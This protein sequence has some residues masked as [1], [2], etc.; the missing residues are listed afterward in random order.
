MF[1]LNQLR[2]RYN[3]RSLSSELA[4]I[5]MINLDDSLVDLR[6]RF[7]QVSLLYKNRPTC[8]REMGKF[9]YYDNKPFSS[10]TIHN[11]LVIFVLLISVRISE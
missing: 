11:S 6:T 8:V 5:V 10:S 7:R 4:S 2:F 1:S 3:R 9:I